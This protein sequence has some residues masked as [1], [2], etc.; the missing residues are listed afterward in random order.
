[1]VRFIWRACLGGQIFEELQLTIIVCPEYPP[2]EI[3]TKYKE[4]EKGK[5]SMIRA[6]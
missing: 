4:K 1:M 3:K 5:E 6:S 2:E